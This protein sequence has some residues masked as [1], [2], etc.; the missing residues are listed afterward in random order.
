MFGESKTMYELSGVEPIEFNTLM[1]RT[2]T[3]GPL[4]FFCYC[5]N[6]DRF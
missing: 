5:H 2:I 4:H 3:K 1:N 6:I